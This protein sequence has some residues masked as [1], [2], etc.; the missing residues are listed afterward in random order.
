MRGDLIP[1]LQ[2]AQE[3]FGYLSQ[4]ALAAISRHLRLSENEIY[5][6]ATFYKQFRFTPPGEHSIRTCVGTACHVRG[7]AKLLHA[8]CNQLEVE[9]GGTTGDGKFDLDR[10][11]CLGCCALAP[12][13]K[14][15]ETVYSQ[16]SVARLRE[17][18]DA[19]RR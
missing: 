5:G 16:M 12:V 3:Q 4:D 2:R 1:L 10:V 13:V 18:I 7:G 19:Y 6:V 8:L 11:A 17:V 15:D 9:P 14:V